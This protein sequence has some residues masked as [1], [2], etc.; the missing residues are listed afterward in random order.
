MQHRILRIKPAE[1][2]SLV[3]AGKAV[4]LDVVAPELRAHMSRQIAGAVRIE[5]EEFSARYQELL[6]RDKQIIAYCTCDDEITSA[7]VA[8]DLRRHGYEAFA[9]QGGYAAWEEAGY[10]TE[11]KKRPAVKVP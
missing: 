11:P 1:A 3:D 7:D 2:M 10:P 5:P 8:R 6:P 9:L 4:V